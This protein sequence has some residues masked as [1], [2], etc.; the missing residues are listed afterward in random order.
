[1]S[2]KPQRLVGEPA[3]R[4]FV[5]DLCEHTSQTEVAK[6]NKL[7]PSQVNQ[8]LSGRACLGNKTVAKFGFKRIVSVEFVAINGKDP[9]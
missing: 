1:M 9:S 5:R 6:E 2:K 7:T 3:F 8:I 4:A